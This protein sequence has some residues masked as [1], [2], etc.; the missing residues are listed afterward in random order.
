MS[1]RRLSAAELVPEVHPVQGEPLVFNV[2]SESRPRMQHRVDMSMYRGNGW[3]GC[4]KFVFKGMQARMERGE[5]PHRRSQCHH[6]RKV[7]EYQSYVLTEI[8]LQAIEQVEQD[9]KRPAVEKKAE[10]KSALDVRHKSTG[11]LRGAPARTYVIDPLKKF[12]H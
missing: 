1:K 7:R 11:P 8:T 2:D 6:I 5:D 12:A 3:C 10:A 4:E 9:S